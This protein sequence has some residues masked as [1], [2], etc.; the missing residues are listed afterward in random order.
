MVPSYYHPED[1]KKLIFDRLNV[2]VTHQRLKLLD[3]AG[4]LGEVERS[5][6]GHRLFTLDQV[7]LATSAIALL[8]V[9][10]PMETVTAFVRP[11]NLKDASYEDAEKA[12]VLRVSGL[13]EIIRKMGALREGLRHVITRL[14]SE[15][16]DVG[17]LVTREL[18]ELS[19]LPRKQRKGQ[20]KVKY[21]KRGMVAEVSEQIVHYLDR[22]KR[23]LDDELTSR[24]VT[25]D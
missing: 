21:T 17:V 14:E 1:V 24:S 7:R 4:I 16:P 6:G 9:G 20:V 19:K 2:N 12:L 11:E 10:L 8:E 18:K 3:D 22:V 13:I 15:K 23:F 5:E 25:K